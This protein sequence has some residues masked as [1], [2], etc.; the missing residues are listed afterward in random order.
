[1]FST[2]WQMLL[3]VLLDMIWTRMDGKSG[4]PN[5]S[6]LKCC[7]EARANLNSFIAAIG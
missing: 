6:S 5:S 4:R 1:M 7:D 2:E 3:D